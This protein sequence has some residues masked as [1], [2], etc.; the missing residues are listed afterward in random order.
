M[1]YLVVSKVKVLQ[2]TGWHHPKAL[3]TTPIKTIKDISSQHS[4]LK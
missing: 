1:E 4:Y 3:Q 2:A